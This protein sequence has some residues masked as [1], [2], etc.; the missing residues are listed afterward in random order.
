MLYMLYVG[1]DLY[2]K[3]L[4]G[5]LKNIICRGG[6]FDRPHLNFGRSKGTN[7]F[8]VQ[9]CVKRP[10]PIFGT[11]HKYIHIYVMASDFICL[12]AVV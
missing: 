1:V 8:A 7:K 10:N 9:N 2:S 4:Y 5:R 11:N 3:K 12:L 6:L